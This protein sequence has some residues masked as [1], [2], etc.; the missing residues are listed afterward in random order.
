LWES[1][2]GYLWFFVVYIRKEIV[3][4]SP[5]ISDDTLRTTAIVPEIS[6]TLLCKDCVIWL[7]DYFSRSGKISKVV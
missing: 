3:L 5:L 1:N 7:N 4:E 6:E 2:S